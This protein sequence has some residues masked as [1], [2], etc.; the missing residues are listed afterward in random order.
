MQLTKKYIICIMCYVFCSCNK[1]AIESSKVTEQFRRVEAVFIHK[2][3]LELN[4]LNGIWFYNK[5]PFNGV[6]LN[7]YSNG[8]VSEKTGYKNGKREGET[9]KFFEDGTVKIEACYQSNKLKGKKV[10][11]FP[12]GKIL[13]ISNF[14]N[15]KRNGIQKIFYA[16]GQLAKKKNMSNGLED[17]LQQAWLENGK[18]YVN[19]EAK[20]GRIFGLN[21]ANLCYKLKNEK[22]QYASTK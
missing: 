5:R 19:Y 4:Q 13:S 18:L 22:I 14:K 8:A 10:V 3:Q 9:V 2:N 12:N 16:S 15:G 6:A 21:R 7:Y 17:G 11:Y 1:E 20:N